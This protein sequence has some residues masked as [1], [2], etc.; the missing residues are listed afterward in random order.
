MVSLG[1]VSKERDRKAAKMKLMIVGY[2][3]FVIIS[4][5]TVHERLRERDGDRERRGGEREADRRR[6]G[7]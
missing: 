2:A 1:L 4:S 3:G 6:F 5:V 7:E